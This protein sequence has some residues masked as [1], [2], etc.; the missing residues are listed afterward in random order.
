MQTFQ[1]GIQIR[2]LSVLHIIFGFPWAAAARWITPTRLAGA[3]TSR[4]E[5]PRRLASASHSPFSPVERVSSGLPSSTCPRPLSFVSAHQIA[6]LSLRLFRTFVTPPTPIST[7]LTT[8][9]VNVLSTT[10]Q[11]RA[12]ERGPRGTLNISTTSSDGYPHPGHHLPLARGFHVNKDTSRSLVT[13]IG[14]VTRHPSQPI[15][16]SLLL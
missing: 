7:R 2:G 6:A 4:C 3:W 14:G 9:T 10:A 11:R 12:R 15:L 1:A 16:Y 8:S 13:V 5:Y